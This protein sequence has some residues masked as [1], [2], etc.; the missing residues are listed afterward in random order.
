MQRSNDVNLHDVHH[1]LLN[2]I[3]VISTNAE[4]LQDSS[5]DAD[6]AEI[7]GDIVSA[8]RKAIEASQELR[9]AL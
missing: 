6:Q 5:L 1:D 7:V 4:L 8:A 2:H 3:A 9:A